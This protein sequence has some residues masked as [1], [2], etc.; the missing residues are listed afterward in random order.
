MNELIDKLN[1]L[2]ESNWRT[3]TGVYL[4]SIALL[5]GVRRID[6]DDKIRSDHEVRDIIYNIIKDN[7]LD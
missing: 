5:Y 6:D 1:F 7:S 3:A 4:D 2:L